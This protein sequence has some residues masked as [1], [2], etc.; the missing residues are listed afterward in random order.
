MA[1]SDE[2]R[3]TASAAGHEAPPAAAVLESENVSRSR[4]KTKPGPKSKTQ[5][6]RE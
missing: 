2:D 5:V 4:K 1:L 6:A 3:V